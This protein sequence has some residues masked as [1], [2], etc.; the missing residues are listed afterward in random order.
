MNNRRIVKYYTNNGDVRFKRQ[1]LV[2]MF[3]FKIFE[4]EKFLFC[5]NNGIGV[6]KINSFRPI[7]FKDFDSAINY[8]HPTYDDLVYKGVRVVSRMSDYGEKILFYPLHQVFGVECWAGRTVCDG[9]VIAYRYYHS[10]EDVKKAI[11]SK[12]NIIHK[13]KKAFIYYDKI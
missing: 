10:L 11:D 8:I 7:H 4:D 12:I 6:T 13:P 9:T 1:I 2:S 3:F 5:D